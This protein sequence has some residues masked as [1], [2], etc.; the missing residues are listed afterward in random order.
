MHQTL[1]DT[2]VHKITLVRDIKHPLQTLL[3]THSDTPQKH[4]PADA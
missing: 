2:Q 1:L 4:F 3:F